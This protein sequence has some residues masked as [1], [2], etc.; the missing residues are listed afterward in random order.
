MYMLSIFPRNIIGRVLFRR[1]ETVKVVYDTLN[2]DDNRTLF[3]RSPPGSGKSIFLLLWGACLQENGFRVFLLNGSTE[4]DAKAN[5]IR[6]TII[7]NTKDG[8]KTV[9]LVD[10]ISPR[11]DFRSEL[12]INILKPTSPLDDVVL[13]AAGVSSLIDYSRLFDVRFDAQLLFYKDGS[14]D[15]EETI[16][17]W[18]T[19][20]PPGIFSKEQ[21]SDI[22]KFIRSHTGGH[23]FP[24][25]K[26]CQA[27]FC[28]EGLADHVS[29]PQVFICSKVFF[30]LKIVQD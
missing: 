6:S 14:G 4:F 19:I 23:P 17:Y 15:L 28:D 13:V 8:C 16:S 11:S 3:L 20:A 29:N 12:W 5:A 18:Q 1:R 30:N 21:V 26:F 9:L 25:F 22:V 24:F 7:A 2:Q 27:L 10:E